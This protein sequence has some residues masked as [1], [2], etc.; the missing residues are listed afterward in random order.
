M[1]NKTIIIDKFNYNERSEDEW[2][3]MQEAVRKCREGIR[4]LS[5]EWK[6]RLKD[7][8]NA[9]DKEYKDYS[10]QL[11][12]LYCKYKSLIGSCWVMSDKDRDEAI[13]FICPYMISEINDCLFALYSE[14]GG[15]V[16][17]ALE[18]KS[19]S[20]INLSERNLVFKEV[21]EDVLLENA[22]SNCKNMLK[23]RTKSKDIS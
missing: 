19:L 20:M 5:D 22:M 2:F 18:D 14:I 9:I 3:D 23:K 4:D 10:L 12:A 1:E 11:D 7:F 17:G 13:A 21:S 8:E 6:D 15:N 16:Y